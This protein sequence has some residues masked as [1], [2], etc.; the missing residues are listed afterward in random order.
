FVEGDHRCI[1]ATGRAD[2]LVVINQRRLAISPHGHV[3]SSEVFF[4]VLVPNFLSV[5]YLQACEF[6]LGAEGIDEI[7]I[8]RWG[9]AGALAAC[10]WT[11]NISG[12]L[13][14]GSDP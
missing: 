2:Q 6:A 7:A 5:S 13:G 14:N 12:C 4:Q 11:T 8:N 3:A 10:I 9:T 1:L